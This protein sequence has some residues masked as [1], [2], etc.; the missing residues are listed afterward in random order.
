MAK[1]QAVWSGTDTH[2][3][4]IEVAQ[5]EAGKFFWREFGWNGYGNTWSKW[6]EY[7][8]EK[9]VHPARIPCRAEYANAPE[10]I[11]IPEESRKNRIEWGFNTLS[12]Q[13]GP[14]RVRLP[15]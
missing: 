15:N 2:G 6:A 3:R 10:W 12:I 13:P 9:I 8:K 7:N 14:Y 11:D 4:Y 1:A 5:N